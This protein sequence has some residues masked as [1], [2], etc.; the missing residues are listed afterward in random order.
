MKFLDKKASSPFGPFVPFVTF[1]A[2]VFAVGVSR[3][4]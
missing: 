3:G 2:L 4:E 1:V